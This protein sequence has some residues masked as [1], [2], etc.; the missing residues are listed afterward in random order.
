MEAA[1]AFLLCVRTRHEHSD[2]ETTVYLSTVLCLFLIVIV[3]VAVVYNIP[4]TELST[5]TYVFFLL[6]S[7]GLLSIRF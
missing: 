2:T 4:G 7:C 6:F 3:A 1:Y 5:E